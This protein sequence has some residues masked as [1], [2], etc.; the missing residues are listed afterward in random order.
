M[1]KSKSNLLVQFAKIAA[2]PT[3]AVLCI[4]AFYEALNKLIFAPLWNA[5]DLKESVPLYV[6]VLVVSCYLVYV[7]FCSR[8]KAIAD[9]HKRA[10]VFAILLYVY[11]WQ[12]TNWSLIPLNGCV[13]LWMVLLVAFPLGYC[14]GKVWLKASGK[15]K[16]KKKEKKPSY[17]AFSPIAIISDDPIDEL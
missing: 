14:A 17:L 13:D 16:E 7:G 2:L 9:S 1:E 15:Y 5:L 8:T 11:V 3:F 6:M 12:Y 10:Y 4:A